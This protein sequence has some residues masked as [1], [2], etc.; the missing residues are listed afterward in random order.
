M[1][2]HIRCGTEFAAVLLGE[3]FQ[4]FSRKYA[5]LRGN[6]SLLGELNG[7]SEG[8]G[9]LKGKVRFCHIVSCYLTKLSVAEV[10]DS[11][12]TSI[13]LSNCSALKN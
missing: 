12:S 4:L 8:Q 1:T 2:A 3:H 9:Y 5:L 11:S 10:G 6:D 7:K 13:K